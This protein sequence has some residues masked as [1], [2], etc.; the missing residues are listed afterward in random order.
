MREFA[1]QEDLSIFGDTVDGVPNPLIGH[2]HPY[3][4]RFHGPIFNQPQ[5]GQPYRQRPYGVAPYAGIGADAATV[6]AT[7]APVTVS[8]V[9]KAL[10]VASMAASAYHGYKRH[11]SIGWALWWGL[12]GAAFPIITPV[13]AVAQG[14]G[15]EQEAK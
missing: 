7:P 11:E 1:P 15:A 5:F 2:V 3:P 8:P 6:P 4:T 13:I 12:M 10:M 9:W 14:F